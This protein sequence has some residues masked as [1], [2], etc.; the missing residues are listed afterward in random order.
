MTLPSDPLELTV[1]L[2]DHLSEVRYNDYG[3]LE[4]IVPDD[5]D[6]GDVRDALEAADILAPDEDP[7]RRQLQILP[8]HSYFR[9]VDKLLESPSRRSAIPATFYIHDLKYFYKGAIDESTPLIISQYHQAV[10]LMNALKSL[11]DDTRTFGSTESLIFLHQTKLEIT[12]TYGP[13]D[14]SDIPGLGDFEDEFSTTATHQKQKR[15]IIKNVLFDV[16]GNDKEVL[17]GSIIGRFSQ[18]FEKAEASYQL[19]VS[20]FSFEK[21]KEEVEREKLE[22]TTKL[23]KVFSDIQNQLLAIPVALILIGGQMKPQGLWSI[24]NSLIFFGAVVF[25]ILMNLL[26][27]NQSHT[28]NAIKLEMDEQWRLIRGKHS[29]VAGQFED[30]YDQ[31]DKRYMHQRNLLATIDFLVAIALGMALGLLIWNSAPRETAC[32][33]IGISATLFLIMIFVRLIC[34]ACKKYCTATPTAS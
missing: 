26:I 33:S 4:G 21:I 5:L 24:T 18:I 25:S 7:D 29:H 1:Y 17:F 12:N 6:F 23:N 11:A 19:Y 9:S 34:R 10:R 30:S 22:F 14:L 28:L 13:S 8:P 15:T 31:L 32:Q 3:N 16:F 2:A 27:R 20:E